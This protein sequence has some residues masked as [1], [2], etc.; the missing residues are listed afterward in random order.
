MPKPLGKPR[1]RC[2]PFAFFLNICRK[3]CDKKR[4]DNDKEVDF[5]TL[6]SLAWERWGRMTEAQKKR[7]VQM[8]E[9]DQDRLD[10]EMKEYTE[11][12]KTKPE[13]RAF[14]ELKKGWKNRRSGKIKY[15]SPED[16]EETKNLFL[17]E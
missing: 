1:G 3:K 13:K 9:C 5:K 7:I 17:I 2:T 4:G 15:F 16:A 6:S 14:E 12:K 11:A 10:K 8:S